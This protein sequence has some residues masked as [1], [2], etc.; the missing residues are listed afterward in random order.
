MVLNQSGSSI[1]VFF[2]P[3]D[4]PLTSPVPPGFSPQVNVAITVQ[5]NVILPKAAW[6][7]DDTTSCVYMRFKHKD[8]GNWNF[9]FGPGEL[10][11]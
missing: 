2:F 11:R 6:E 10:V 4:R 1:A 5:F 9:D 3:C 7:W 8:L